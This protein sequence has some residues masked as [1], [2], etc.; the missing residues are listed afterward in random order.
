MKLK[1]KKLASL[2]LVLA[3]ILTVCGA[4]GGSSGSSGSSSGTGDTAE[5]SVLKVGLDAEPNSLDPNVSSGEGSMF[6][7]M[8]IYDRLWTFNADGEQQMCLAESYEYTGDLELTVKLRS[9]AKFSDGTQ[10]TADDVLFTMQYGNTQASAVRVLGSIDVANCRADDATTLVIALN[11]T[12]PCLLENLALLDVLE[13]AA[14]SDGNGGY[15]SDAINVNVVASGAYMVQTWSSGVGITLVKNPNYYNAD[16]LKYDT[17]EVS[18]IGEENTRLLDF[19]SGNYDIIYLS[20]SDNI[21]SISNGEVS[22][23]SLYT[24]NIQSIGGFVMNTIDF[25]TFQDA[26]VR[27]AIAHALNIPEM[28]NTICGSAYRVATSTLLP[29][30]NWAYEQIGDES[31]GVYSYDPDLAREYLAKA[32]YGEGELTFTCRIMD[33]DYNKALAEAAQ[34]YLADVGIDMKVDVGDAATVMS[35]MIGNQ[36]SFGWSNYMGS[37]DPAG[38]INSRLDSAPANLSKIGTPDLGTQALLVA[39]C[40]STEDQSVRKPMFEQVQE[41]MYD[42]ATW[43]PV[44]ESTVNYAVYNGVSDDLKS[45][46]QADG[47]LYASNLYQ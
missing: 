28:V 29:A 31:T 36:I 38:L 34:A 15:N 14:C 45:T 19:E 33:Q 43:I 9:D 2:G 12:D 25:D 16:K 32:G 3:M 8:S 11:N 47:Y 30:A 4:C 41:E 5:A 35:E 40:T 18:F 42:L 24:V 26:N 37:Y 7:L 10:I 17:I 20:N 23:A 44:Y 13:K 21:D 1:L 39:A 46:T 6:V 22:N 27:L